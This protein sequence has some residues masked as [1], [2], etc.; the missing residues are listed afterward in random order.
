MEAKIFLLNNTNPKS[1]LGKAYNNH[2]NSIL[3]GLDAES[4]DRWEVYNLIINELMSQGDVD[5]FKELQYRLTDGENPNQIILDMIEREK[6]NV[7]S[8]VW[9][10]KRRVEEYLDDDSFNEFLL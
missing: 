3:D 5:Y 10:L 4:E 6:E 2:I 1:V 8:L 9:Y 7:T